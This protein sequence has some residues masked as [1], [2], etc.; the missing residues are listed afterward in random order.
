MRRIAVLITLICLLAVP[1]AAQAATRHL[2]SGAGFG[3]GVGMSQYGAFGFAKEG[4]DYESIL[5]HYYRGTKLSKA[6]SDTIRVLLQQGKSAISFSG[7]RHVGSKR[8]NPTRI[9]VAKRKGSRVEVRRVTDRKLVGTFAAPLRVTGSKSTLVR[10]LGPAIGGVLSGRYRGA[11]E[12]RPSGLGGV[13]AVNA[14]S[15]DDYV[16]G[17]IPGEVPPTWPTE[18]VKAQAVA[19]RSYALTTD[20][21]GDIFDQYPDTRSQVYRGAD[22]EHPLSNAATQATAGQVLRYDGAVIPTFFFSTSGGR[23]ENVENSFGGSAPK[24]YLVSVKDPYDFHS[25]KHRW[26]FRFTTEQM[27]D[28]LGSLL[29]GD[30]EAIT[31]LDRGVS[32]RIISAD[33][34]GSKGRTRVSGATLRRELGLYDTWASFSTVD[35]EGDTERVRRARSSSRV[36]ARPSAGSSWLEQMLD[37]TLLGRREKVDRGRKAR[38]A[39]RRVLSGR[40]LPRPKREL[41]EVE[42]RLAPKR[43][44]L[45]RRVRTTRNGKFRARLQR[46]GVYRVRSGRLAGAGVRLK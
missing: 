17:V 2:V 33:V 30:F 12:L 37:P 34:V 16:Q 36:L 46:P 14:V 31:V 18:A 15:L 8:A 45:V 35:T 11:M 38:S 29:K 9:Y 13:T 42:R 5:T 44:R 32:P 41:L 27:E 22:S 3:H 40:F 6:S 19:A 25:P 1:A 10:L 23:T 26:T 43:W 21:G 7:A 24:P 28:K 39:T 20:A 4:R